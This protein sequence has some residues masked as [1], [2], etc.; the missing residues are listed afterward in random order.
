MQKR[1]FFPILGGILMATLLLAVVF[2]YLFFHAARTQEVTAIQDK[3]YL[4]AEILNQSPAI[5]PEDLTV[6]FDGSRITII[7]ADG[8]VLL[9]SHAPSQDLGGRYDR[10]EFQLATRYGSGEDI[11]KSTVFE[12]ETYYY[13]LRLENGNILRISR[14][15][16]S[17][18]GAFATILPALFV[19]AALAVILTYIIAQKR[20]EVHKAEA[21]RREFSANV[22][23]ELKT[24]L[25]TISALSEMMA[26]GMAKQEDF[27]SFA[28]K[29]STQ[30]KRLI[31]I[32]E[33]IIRLSEFDE[34]KVRREYIRFDAHA[35]AES[36]IDDLQE[37]AEKKH[38]TLT[39][40]GTP[41]QLTANQRLM[42]ELLF[43]LVENGIKYNKESGQVTL[44]VEKENDMCK[45]TAADTGIGIPKDHQ[46]HVFERFYR[47]DNSRARNTGG[48]GLGL[49]IVKHIVEHH[50]G[51]ISMESTE[52]VGTTITCWFPM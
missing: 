15:L 26:N 7:A 25:T 31:A 14:P 42:E 44:T 28:G 9:D 37:R 38:V 11:R 1:I 49:S 2:S 45:I 29:I 39:L 27:T 51:T 22:S 35:L 52:G 24:P 47:V 3:T 41:V 17:L 48:S 33:D 43:N 40:H 34:K 4:I 6:P 46:K 13:A 18:G 30:S 16:N 19:V 50:K 21:Q 32:I 20:S 5:I 10:L 36:V 8:T 23:H 12:R